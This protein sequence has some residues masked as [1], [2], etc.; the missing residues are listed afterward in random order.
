MMAMAL[1][2]MP[3]R[4]A[5]APATGYSGCAGD[6]KCA[7][8]RPG[9]PGARF[10]FVDPGHAAQGFAG[11]G[12]GMSITGTVGL[13][14][15]SRSASWPW[16]AKSIDSPR[17]RAASCGAWNP[18]E[19]SASTKS[20]I[21]LR[22]PLQVAGGEEVGVLATR[23]FR[24]LQVVDQRHY[25]RHRLL[26]KRPVPVLDLEDARL[27]V[28]RAGLRV[29]LLVAGDAGR[30]HVQ[31]GA[32][33]PV[34]RERLGER[35]HVAMTQVTPARACGP[36]LHVSNSGCC[37]LSAGAPVSLWVQSRKPISS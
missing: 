1:S 36:W 35:R 12:G 32:A 28:F 2:T 34:V 37:A 22:A 16:R 15:G 24:R 20:R 27:E 4:E 31:D 11:G 6:A 8:A 29:V 9:R 10:G 17:M 18:V 33:H 26:A 30:L 7:L 14:A 13:N 21:E 5:P 19:F 23:R 3:S 25:R